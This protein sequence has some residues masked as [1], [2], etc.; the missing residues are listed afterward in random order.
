LSRKIYCVASS[1]KVHENALFR[2]ELHTAWRKIK[3]PGR[4]PLWSL[5]I[6]LYRRPAVYLGAWFIDI[7]HIITMV[8]L[9]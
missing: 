5:L 1:R 6:S 2:E 7:Y 3:I 9:W 8:T 4:E